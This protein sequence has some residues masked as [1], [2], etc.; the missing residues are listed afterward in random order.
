MT[1][2]NTY[3]RDLP[4]T[5]NVA[6]TVLSLKNIVKTFGK[7]VAL[8]NVSFD[9]KHG[10]VHALLGENGAGKS[11]LM[12]VVCGLYTADS[13]TIL[14]YGKPILIKSPNEAHNLGIGMVHQHYKLVKPFTALE[15]IQLE[16]GTGPYKA[17]LDRLNAKAV[18]VSER[19]GFTVGLHTPVGQLSISE[20]QRVEILKVLTADAKI[21]IL[22]E[23]TAVLT[24]SESDNLFT[25]MRSLA[26]SGC[27]VV[28]VT[29]KLREAL[30][31]ADRIT[32]MRN[33][34]T[35]DTVLPKNMDANV[36]ANLIVGESVVESP[37]R[38]KV[39]TTPKIMIDRLSMADIN[40]VQVISDLSFN[41]S[42]GEIYG[43]AGV[44]GNGQN[45]LVS[46]LSGLLR[47]DV[48]T[49]ELDGY[50]NIEAAK[51]IELRNYGV[52]CIHSD[53]ASH[54]LANDLNV[55]EN[56]GISSVLAGEFGKLVVQRRRARAAAAQAI[57]DFDVRGV[58]SQGQKAGLLSGG[59]AQK[60]VIAR[61]FSRLPKIVVAHSPCRGLDVRAS[62]AVHEH[63]L[64]ARDR[65][66]AVILISEDLDEVMLMS[67]RIGVMSRGSIIAEFEVPADRNKIGKAMAGNA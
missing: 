49:I 60:L 59:N 48:G 10:E 36:L 33:G 50:G 22:D 54:G 18:E 7:F 21:I 58:R 37:K 17:S 24:D 65:G 15:N 12:N 9:L 5:D 46:I 16:N 53:R 44:G 6:G 67:D 25:A 43:I 8:D 47:A 66:G 14:H 29:H 13:G 23:P 35:V 3:N 19:I 26:A 45:E 64:A 55:D 4:A 61:E 1:I 51:P 39:V 56:F 63:L 62:S 2:T 57:Q 34:I 11:T 30:T 41:V 40:G 52:A 31:F 27:S 38:S 32:V 28:F 20:Q 42:S